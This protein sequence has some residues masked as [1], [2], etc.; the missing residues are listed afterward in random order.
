[1]WQFVGCAILTEV[2]RGWKVRPVERFAG[3]F[4]GNTSFPILLIGNT[5][6]P[7]TPLTQYVTML[8]ND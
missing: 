7:M 1:M 3:P 4:V 6:D 5:A 2:R 8:L